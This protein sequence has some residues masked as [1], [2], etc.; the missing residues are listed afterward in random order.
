MFSPLM[1][2]YMESTCSSLGEL[3]RDLNTDVWKTTVPELASDHRFVR[4]GILAA[5]S[6]PDRTLALEHHN[7]GL[8]MFIEALNSS[9]NVDALFAHQ[10]MMLVFSYGYLEKN[11]SGFRDV[12]II[13]RG[14]S[15]VI[16]E[17][18]EPKGKL[19]ALMK[20]NPEATSVGMQILTDKLLGSISAM[21]YHDLYVDAIKRLEYSLGVAKDPQYRQ[22]IANNVWFELPNEFLN[23]VW[24]GEPLALAIMAGFGVALH[25]SCND[26]A[27]TK[28]W[29][30]GIVESV[31]KVLGPEWDDIMIWAMTEVAD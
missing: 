26:N 10:C 1:M 13:I 15:V 19:S 6:L 5:A 28:G 17:K 23:L 25:W 12:V 29:G 30:K 4:H 7:I 16:Q 3:T 22:I 27:F 2:K 20:D 11:L 9:N 14:T 21:V 18:G 24:L 8:S 31:G